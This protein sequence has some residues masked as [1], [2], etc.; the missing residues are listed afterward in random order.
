MYKKSSVPTTISSF[1][2][3]PVDGV[4]HRNIGFRLFV[5]RFVHCFRL[6]FWS[7]KSFEI[8]ENLIKFVNVWIALQLYEKF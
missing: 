4:A 8:V 5:H 3:F 6:A 2:I 7:I 1:Y